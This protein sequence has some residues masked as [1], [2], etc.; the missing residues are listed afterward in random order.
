LGVNLF[1]GFLS[2]FFFPLLFLV[3]HRIFCLF[4]VCVVSVTANSN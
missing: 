1:F 4:V 2:L 3:L